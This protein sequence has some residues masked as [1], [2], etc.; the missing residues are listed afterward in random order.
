MHEESGRI[1]RPRSKGRKD[2]GRAKAQQQGFL[3]ATAVED[4]KQVAAQTR[5][6]GGLQPGVMQ[7]GPG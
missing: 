6:V 2:G 4:C 5:V 1:M 3:N 7:Q